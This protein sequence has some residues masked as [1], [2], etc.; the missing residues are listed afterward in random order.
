M[1]HKY[2]T[3]AL[4][5]QTSM[6]FEMLTISN[7]SD[8]QQS[9]PERVHI[10]PVLFL[11]LSK[12][13]QGWEG[14]NGHGYQHHQKS[15]FLVGLLE[16]A[17]ERLKS[18]KVSHEL[19]DSKDP[20]H[21]DETEDLAGLADDVELWEVVNQEGDKVGQDCKQVDLKNNLSELWEWMIE[22]KFISS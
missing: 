17:E 3:Y 18:G 12:V 4:Q 20:G 10:A 15:K 16:G 22:W 14:Q 9:P 5:V 21:T 2:T 13:N 11:L 6:T 7:G 19:E 8:G 1:I